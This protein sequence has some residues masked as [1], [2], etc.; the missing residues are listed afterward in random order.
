M[1]GGNEWFPNS[2]RRY[3]EL[4]LKGIN[5][6][7]M[8][9]SGGEEVSPASLCCPVLSCAVLCCPVLSTIWCL[10]L[11]SGVYSLSSAAGCQLSAVTHL[12]SLSLTL[13]FLLVVT[14][15]VLA[16]APVS[17]LAVLA[18]CSTSL[19]LFSP[20]AR[21]KLMMEPVP[22]TWVLLGLVIT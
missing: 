21:R 7:G 17:C 14:Y 6:V 16:M 12:P 18:K 2:I 8:G 5:F 10:C 1:D 19:P 13:F 22:P 9:I 3:D 15:R 11:V 20:S 4:A